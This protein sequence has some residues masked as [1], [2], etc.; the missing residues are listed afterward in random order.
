MLPSGTK[1]YVQVDEIQFQGSVTD[2]HYIYFNKLS[3]SVISSLF[4]RSPM[5]DPLGDL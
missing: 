3:D 5:P 1:K 4:Q 2:I